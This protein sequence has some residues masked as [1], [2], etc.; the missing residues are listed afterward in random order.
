VQSATVARALRHYGQHIVLREAALGVQPTAM[1]PLSVAGIEG[2]ED[3]E[4]EAEIELPPP[5][6]LQVSGC[7]L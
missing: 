2:E 3:E 5:E 6:E 4:E 7:C 1:P